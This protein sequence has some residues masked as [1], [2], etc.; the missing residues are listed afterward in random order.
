MDTT[1]INMPCELNSE[2]L[3]N[4]LHIKPDS[5]FAEKVE[6]LID[7]ALKIGR[8]KIA[9]KLAYIDNKGE[10]FV[11]VEGI[12]FSSRVLRINLEE[13]YKV[14]PYIVTCGVELEQWGKN[15]NDV[16]DNFITDTIME[17]AV[18]SAR[19]KVLSQIDAEFNLSNTVTMNPGSLPDWPIKEQKPLF[20]LLGNVESL[21]G[22]KLMDSY[23]MSPIKTVSG[24]YFSKKGGFES[25]QLC[26]RDNCPGRRA[27]YDKNLYEE[28]YQPK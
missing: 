22:V 19:R 8:P 14:V 25:C 15:Y 12:K 13:T 6:Q 2:Q 16:F 9:Y 18:R 21:I 3:F 26:A 7:E 11:V 24:L 17:A 27:P 5:P 28:K 20:T 10:D 1:V 4:S 23:L